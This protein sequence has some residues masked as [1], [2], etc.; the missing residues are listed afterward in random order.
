MSEIIKIIDERETHA[1]TNTQHTN[2]GRKE[3]SGDASYS[4]RVTAK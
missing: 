2:K 3:Q 1:N 4:E